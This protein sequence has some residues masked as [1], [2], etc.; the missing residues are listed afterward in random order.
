MLNVDI[1][2]N[3]INPWDQDN[4]TESK[5]K[6]KIKI[7]RSIPKQLNIERFYWE[8]LNKKEKD[9]VIGVWNWKKIYI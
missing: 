4:F 7:R 6:L 2:K 1:M 9:W 8:K 3:K 5:L